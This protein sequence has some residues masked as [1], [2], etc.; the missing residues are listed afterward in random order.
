MN[1]NSA[2]YKS[3]AY[4]LF[5]FSPLSSSKYFS[6]LLFSKVKNS[7]MLT[8]YHLKMLNWSV[9]TIMSLITDCSMAVYL[10]WFSIM[11]RLYAPVS[12]FSVMSGR[13]HCFLGITST[14]GE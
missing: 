11:L 4:V 14:F 2:I 6:F 13:S 10:L 8:Q 7:Y 3:N 12:N 5:I 9:V 1:I